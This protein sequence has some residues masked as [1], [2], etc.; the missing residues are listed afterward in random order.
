MFELNTSLSEIRVADD[1]SSAL[2]NFEPRIS[3]IDVTVTVE[4]DSHEL[5]CTVQYEIVGIPSPT[6][7]VDVILQPARI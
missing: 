7:E 5:N 1:I 4:P 6:Q 3:E 2:L